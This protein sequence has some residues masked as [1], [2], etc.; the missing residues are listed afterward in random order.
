MRRPHEKN[1]VADW[2]ALKPLKPSYALVGNVDLVVIRQSDDEVSVLCGR[3]LHRGALLA[4][5]H[6][7]GN[8]LICG[9]HNWD[10]SCKTGI[11]SY[12]PS[13]RLKRFDAWLADGG[14]WVNEE[15]IVEWELDNPQPYNRDAYQELY[16][17]PRGTPLE[18]HVGYIQHLGANGRGINS[19]AIFAALSRQV[20]EDAI[21]A[22]DVGNN[23]YSFGRYFECASQPGLMSGY[24][25]SIG[26]SFPAAMG[27]WAA[28]QEDDPRFKGR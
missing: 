24:L 12:K 6:V 22:V 1:K 18:P 28:T 3:C 25:G 27:A 26:F 19:A 10:Y 21:I 9:L 7:E 8:N 20:A 2:D 15:D 14:A 16:A 17:D 5:G 13:E 4:D 11:C 23:T